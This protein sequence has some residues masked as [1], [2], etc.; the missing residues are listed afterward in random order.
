MFK[1]IKEVKTKISAKA[2]SIAAAGF[3]LAAPACAYADGAIANAGKKA[4][5]GILSEAKSFL[6]YLLSIVLVIIGIMLISLGQRGKEGA[7]Q[8]APQVI[9]GIA[10]V[11]FAGSV[12]TLLIGWFK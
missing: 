1:K 8:Q 12:A 7:K 11:M 3:V 10:C 5:E 2:I 4:S 6:P 9:I